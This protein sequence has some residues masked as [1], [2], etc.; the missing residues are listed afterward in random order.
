MSKQIAITLFNGAEQVLVKNGLLDEADVH[1][2]EVNAFVHETGF[3]CIISSE[4]LRA[5]QL[6]IINKQMVKL[7]NGEIV[8]L[9]VA[10]P[11][12]LQLNGHVNTCNA[13]VNGTGKHVSISKA[14]IDFL[15][16]EYLKLPLL[17]PL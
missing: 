15:T 8:C 12:A 1:S 7:P 2:V 17:V 6:P 9:D 16:T 13:L 5:L 4:I 10:G 11:L 14:Q 3:S